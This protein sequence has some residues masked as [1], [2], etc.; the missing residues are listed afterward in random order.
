MNKFIVGNWKMNG[1]LSLV[2]A[3]LDS[4]EEQN[5]AIAI[6]QV[7]LAYAYSRNPKFKLVAQN[8][9]IYDKFGAHTG[10]IS[11]DILVGLGCQYVIIG[12]SERRH[13]FEEDNTSN[14]LKKLNNV[15]SN[16]MTAILCVDEQ[17]ERLINRETSEFIKNNINNVILAY[18][19]LSAIGT[20][21][22]PSISEISNIL[23]L[24][25]QKYFCVNILYGGSVNSKNARDILSISSL[26]GVLVGGAS[27]KLG[28]F[29]EIIAASK[30][31][32]A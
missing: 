22:T 21:K 7:F 4:I 14:I 1:S 10:E 29:K 12:H 31:L 24:L 27:L 23:N 11:A 5:V 15:I 30:N 8:C 18:E 13:M 3:F 32:I 16:N 19:P 17:Y 9:S 26:D 25:K 2:D 28:E 6:P 20:G